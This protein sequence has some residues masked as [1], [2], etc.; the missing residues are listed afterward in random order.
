MRCSPSRVS[1]QD[2]V[3]FSFWLIGD[4]HSYLLIGDSYSY[5]LIGGSLESP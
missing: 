4:S 1:V 5:L 3:E 2:D